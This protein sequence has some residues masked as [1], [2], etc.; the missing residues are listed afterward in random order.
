[1]NKIFKVVWSKSKNCYVVV[2]EFAKNNS[3]K[4]KIVVAAI[5]AV[6]AM[7]NASISMAA[8]TLP[9]NLHAT[10]VGLGDGASVTG[11]KAVGFGQNA[12][13]AGGYSIAI[14]SNS[15]TS[16]NSP[17]GIAIGGGNTANEGARVIGEQAIAIGG[18]TIAQ[19]NSSIVIGGDDVVKA[20]SVK[21]IYTTNNGENKTG[22]LRSAVQ[23]LTGFDMRNPLY[24]SATAGESG[25]T[26]G[27]K[28]QSGNVGIAIGTG[29]NAKDRLSGTS[30]GASGQANNDVT[31]AIAIGTGARANRDNAIAIGGGSNTDVGGTKQSSYTLP[32][33]VVASWAG[34]DKTL[35]GD[36]VSFGSKGY[37]RQLKHVAPGEVSATSTDAINGSQ[38]SA[39][40]DQIAYKY[41][42]IKSSDAA[43]KDNTGATADN[44][45]AIGPNAATDASASRSVAVGDGARGKVVD[46]V[47][48]GSKSI[49]DIAS[50]V[51]GYNVNASRTDIYA[52]LSGAALTSKLGGVAVGT[53]NQ[54]RQINYVAAGT[55]DT[56]AVNVAQLKSVNLAFTGDTGTGDVNLANSKLAVNGDNTYISTTA[57]GK[58]IT[59]SGKKQD[60]T[61][62]NGSATATAG[63]A[64]SAN[65]ANAINQAIDQNK[66][67][68]NLSANGEATPVAVEKGNTVDFSGDDNVAVARND[69]KISVALKKDLS[70]L[71]SASFNNASGN[72]TVKIDGDKGINA[73]N[74]K[75][76]NVADG[77]ADKDAV[78]VSQL[79]KVDDKAEANKTAI[80]TN[81]T[82][83][84]KNV[85][86]IATNKTDIATNKDSIAANTQKIVDN[87]T[88]IDKNTGEIATNKAN[89]AQNTAAIARK[90][91]LGGNSGSTDE[92][93]LSTG[94]VK[95]NVK[96]ENGLTTVANGD[97]VTVKLD[98][99]TK[100]KVDN[101]A[102]RDL[103]N[104]TPDGKQQVKDL[105]AWNVVANNETAEKVVGGN[106]V[107]FI[108]GD[109]ISITQN[110]KDF[111]ISTKKDVTFDTVTAIQTI[112]AP[113]VKA[114]TGVETPQVTGLTNT[115]W[116]PGQTQPVS[117]RAA[118]EDQ[119]KQVDDQVADNKANI[120]DNT[121][122]IGKNADAIADNKQKIA[123]NKTAIDKNIGDIATNKAD[124]AT[125]KANIDKNMTAIARKI[126]LGGNSG[127]TDEKSLS[128]GDVKF[129]VKG[130]NGLTTVAN[131]DDVTVK[132]DD[133][134][135]GKVDNAADRDLSNL[136]D[137]GKQQVKDLAAW[138]VVAN[139][140][141]AEKV[142]GGNTVKFIDGDNISITQNGKDFTIS[143]KK[144]VTFDTV[145]ATQTITAPKVK[146]T[147]GVETPQVTGLTNTAWTPGQTQPVSGRA[148]TED[149]LKHV[150]DQ[151]AE[152]KANIA[153]NTDKIG[154]N[155]DAIADN[156]QK[157]ADNK[158][159]I[160]K[161][162]V[163]IATNKDNIATNKADI[164]AN[165]DKIGKNADAIADNKQKIADNKTAIDKNT[166][167][168]ATNK[169][170][171]AANKQKIADNKTAIDKNT[172]DIATNK[173]DIATNKDNI[174]TNKAN[175]DKNTTAIGRKI[176]LGG[177]SGS[178]DEKSL[179]TGDVKF[180]VKGEN[181]LTTVANGDDVTV[182]LDDATKSK[183]DNAADRD[184][185]NL[186]PDGKQQIKDLAAWNVVA[187]NETAEK[188]EGGNTVK[189]I[190]GDN[191]SITQNGKDFT[192]S[193]KKDVTFDTVTATQTITAPKVKATTGVETPQVTGLT[194]IAWVSGQTQP[195]SGRAATEDQLKQVD[196]QVAENKANIA[197]N[198]DKIGK[199]ADA[200][201]DNKQ[202]IADNKTAID[203]NTS[204]IATNKG[205]I[206]QNTA[207]IARKISLG[208]NSGLTDEKS[209]STGD[210]KF[211]VKGE[212]GLTTVANGDDVTVKLDDATK[213]KIDNAADRD[214]SNLTSDGKQ[215]VKDLAAWNVVANNEMA[216][217]VEGGNTVKF[218]DGDNISITQNGKDFTISTKKDVT[219]DTVTA[220]QTITAPKVKATTGVETPQVTGLTNT[221]WVPGQTQPVSGRAATEDQLKHVDDQVAENKANIAANETDIATN[222]DNI[223][224]NKQ[225]IADNKSA[226][227]KNTGDIT[228]NKDNIADNKQKIADNKTAID[229]NTADIATNKGD[230]AS[231]KSNIAQNTAAIARKISLGGNSGST[232]EKSLST[233]DVKFNVK[234]E[235][236]LTTVANGDDVTVK[237][238]DA[239]KGKVDNAADRDLSNLTDT[240]KQ[241]VKDLAVWNV[242]A[243]NETAEKVE[244]G[245]TVKFI[246]GD[247]ISITQNGKDFTISTKKDVTFDTVTATQTITAPK[248]K[249]T[250][251]VET[252]QVIGLTNT[253]WTP[254]Q[255]Q[256][257]SGRA[258]TEDQLK[259][260]DDQVAE[261]KVNI[262]D[263][264]DKIGKN[265]DAIAD[266]KQK[267][268]D[269]KTAIDKNAVDIATNKDNIAANKA[270]IATNKDN[271]ADNKQKIADNKSAIDKNTG[272][273]ATNKDNIAK[274]KDNIDKNTTAIARK[275]SLGGNSGSTN[276]KSLSTG[277]VKFNVKGENGLTTVAN[278]DD[279]TV[280]LDDATKGKVDNAADRDLSNLT[281]D[282]KQQVKDIAAWN[283]VANNETAE[284]VEGGNTVK[285]IDGDNISITQN[286]KDFTVSTKKDVT[287]DTVA[288][289]QTITAPKVKA[290]T[291]VETP[292]VTGLTNTAWT[293]SQTQPVSG[294]AATEDQLKHVD[295]QVA[296]NKANIADN[297][298]KIGK[299]A[300]AIADN[301]QKIADNKAAIDKNAADIA[302]NRDNIATN[303]QNIADNKAA[304]TKNAGDI[305][306][307][308]A[309]IDKNTE[310]IGRKI[311]LGGNTGSTDEKSLSTGDVKFN[312]KGQNGIVTEAN[313]DDV[314]VKL[315]DATANKINNA[316][317]TDLS[318]L[319][320]AGKQQ[321]KDLSAWN[322]VANGNT[323]EKVEGGNT[324]KFID[325]DNI[326]ITQNGKD[327]T[328]ATKQDVTFN[329]VKANQTITAP[330]VKATEGV[331]TPQVTGLTNTAWTPGQTQ[332]V[333]G[334][335]ATED[336]LK[337]VDDQVAENKA[338]IA[339]NIDKIGKNADAI[340]DNKQK[341][342]NNKAAIDRNAADIATNKDNIAA[343]KQNIADNKAAITKNTSDIA[344][345]KDNI[346][347]N[348]ANINKNTTAIARKISLGGNT[349]S[350]DEK[351][352]S[353]GDV[354]FNVKGENGLTTV[355]NG[356]DVTVKLDD[357]TKGKIDNA[358]NQ[359]L[360]NLTDAGK[361]QVKDISAWKVTAAGGTVEKVQGGDTVKFQAG[362]NLVVNQDRTTFTYGL[363]KDL[364]GLNSVTVGDENGVST[365]ITPAGTTVKDAAGNSTT[366]N[367]GGYDY[368]SG[369]CSSWSCIPYCRRFK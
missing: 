268:A 44:S 183:V 82:A 22:D 58:K 330:K 7:T 115:A 368:Y 289:N 321:V 325:G 25:I 358:A 339:D 32:N 275:I 95:F 90:I 265:A 11:D 219:F 129:N 23:S 256:P 24:T 346:A 197:D 76:A 350:T 157:I 240:G 135:K 147:T 232:N 116:V 176:S 112:T 162:A 288:A 204:D 320:D 57:N 8:N 318:N 307:N 300:E 327:F 184:L 63:M 310:A 229:K 26:L 317:N 120:A 308:K 77:V 36:V 45:I 194:N 311:S 189:F 367:G 49:A 245:N 124:I 65:V 209:L 200:I 322:V 238:D 99:A 348:K 142:E 51:A 125:N 234:G 134:T 178:T 303:K 106:T 312:I 349:G 28:G 324:V 215:Q 295:D 230:I 126:S 30:S 16:V 193:T 280:K 225:K 97:D 105:A 185:S 54:T 239:T 102:D 302:T 18:N 248:V 314:T 364:K 158:T 152:N 177:N 292:Q 154:K 306:T 123:D 274:N 64:D 167:D 227:D 1:M 41:I 15:S 61:V 216:E 266:N 182:K 244:G 137:A 205:D 247:N 294:R 39:I 88:A 20:D 139:N 27:M 48:V 340:A 188:V 369:R 284:K 78:N 361:Q 122:K 46:G 296:E 174:A 342:A 201:A 208:G 316:A 186:T 353:T 87:K 328:I 55:A 34:G 192:I 323:A 17:Q 337:H 277:D 69:K 13:A 118:T 243:N 222:K 276:E 128:T 180:N 287:F 252:P 104:L 255:T 263:N 68:W 356:D 354:K 212:N 210:V 196:D 14:G 12:A 6:L 341:I 214:L 198:T 253:A 171:I 164:A 333:S 217:K 67:G 319:T 329:T 70:K 62:A 366:I 117:G 363:A 113:K 335:A 297:T 179:S 351:S 168:I 357:A 236:G 298:D 108:D 235:N 241:Q 143:T 290:T 344:T 291:G 50:G 110:G 132:L 114:T 144:D 19:G 199:N 281:P 254:G 165:T 109:N 92:K 81:K 31:N 33:N 3:G 127:S 261:N 218:I 250:T 258:A 47:A 249:A 83:I 121:D 211:N 262:A 93:S 85:G 9:T 251:G 190:D 100:G 273:I 343:N 191:I 173:A 79:K 233:G 267:I 272:D 86:D 336:Q 293:P 38:L 131:G 84:A 53:I 96:G 347:T 146:A 326:S 98:D 141:T 260:V 352:L 153:D 365:K 151:V 161:N 305:A 228:T 301:K 60:I 130:E 170:D 220:N 119:L 163:D 160:D 37:E 257:V 278:G 331:E 304:I 149:Q 242:V 264:T 269:N 360:S 206:A 150:D 40:V 73:G 362:D 71:N 4:K 246:D 309:N 270:D 285:F 332:P 29:A 66:Y 279:V 156:K 75:V 271:I 35:P 226:I 74:L 21:V 101:A 42:S 213:G 181:G 5:L 355:A 231:N 148:A 175:I 89:I 338:N 103:S 237:L 172:G 59:V 282:G 138:H 111:T 43:N 195:V 299:N 259:H 133:A 187:N 221:A 315:D 10:A 224:D 72:E 169:G 94:D 207:A 91:S 145:T 159:A 203:R 334:R 286:G 140:E 136:T 345:N 359:D 80:G 107:K 283:V 202:K 52:G 166:G 56:D 223:A 313:G 155:A 2:S